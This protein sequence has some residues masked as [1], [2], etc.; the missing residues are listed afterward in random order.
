MLIPPR[1]P[2]ASVHPRSDGFSLVELM[3][4][5][6]L[7]LL[8][9]ASALHL[10]A[11]NAKTLR[12][13]A[14]DHLLDATLDRVMHLLLS[15]ARRAGYRAGEGPPWRV[16]GRVLSIG[17]DD[18]APAASC[19]LYAYDRDGD[20]L[21]GVGREGRFGPDRDRDNMEEFGFR[22]HEGQIQMRL[23]GAAHD[24]RSGRWTAL[25]PPEVRMTG[26][27]LRLHRDPD[28]TQRLQVRIEAVLGDEVRTLESTTWL[29]NT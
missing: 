14:Q 16:R 9:L 24:C 28:G 2:G 25:T 11:L 29:P 10:H 17:A 4:A 21:R 7:S 5:S 20:G 6:T 26:L 12:L 15:E 22:L 18:G 19:L 3:V 23:G 1:A 13:L 8:L 27:D